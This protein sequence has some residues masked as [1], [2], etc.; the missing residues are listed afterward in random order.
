MCQMYY[1]EA[2][3]KDGTF[4]EVAKSAW[5]T[6]AADWHRYGSEDIPTSYKDEKTQEPIVIR[7][8]EEE[9]HQQAAKKLAA[10]LDAL[11]PGLREKLVAEKRA[12]LSTAQ[13]EA[14]D[15]PIEKRTEKQYELATQAEEAI[16]VTHNEVARHITGRNANRRCCLPKRPTDHEQIASY[17][18]RYREIV[19]F[20]YWRLRAEAEQTDDMLTARKL[21]HQGDRGYAEGDLVAARDAY[22]K[23]LREWREVLDKFPSL[24]SD[25]TTGEDLMDVIK[26]YRRILRQ[27]D[28]PFPEK[29]ILQDVIDQQQK[30]HGG[31]VKTEGG[32]KKAEGGGP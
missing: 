27:L 29:F 15:T 21:I 18:G 2:L 10:Q 20:V 31:P 24:V 25:Q 4:G 22:Q 30:M 19:N 28:E 9:M 16:N 13:R 26:R 17:I 3:E 1:A 12:A 23:G 8:N 11:Q 6:A 14:L 5:A 32:G 7:L